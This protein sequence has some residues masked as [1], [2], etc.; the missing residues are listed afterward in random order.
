MVHKFSGLKQ[1]GFSDEVIARLDKV[2][3]DSTNKVYLSQWTLFEA[4]CRRRD[5]NPLSATS[6]CLCDFFV[7]LFKERCLQTKTIEGYRSA[8]SFILKRASR[9][10]LSQC[11]I[12]SD[13]IKSFRLE[14]PR[15]ARTVVQWDLSVVLSLLQSHQYSLEAANVRDL[16][17]RTVFLVALALGKRR[18]ELH[19]IARDSVIFA[20]DLS[21]VTLRPIPGFLSKTHITSRGVGAFRQVRIP[22]LPQEKGGGAHS[23]RSGHFTGTCR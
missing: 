20:D 13:M 5:I 2:H 22:A 7:Y 21:A 4:W 17:L 12:L 10:D 1:Q 18:S 23:A 16:T 6:V 9:Y 15:P 19:A 8:I 11:E 14:R 3:A